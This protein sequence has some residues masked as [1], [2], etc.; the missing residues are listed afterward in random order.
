MPSSLGV[1]ALLPVVLHLWL[2]LL[3]G[4]IDLEL[5]LYRYWTL[6][7]MHDPFAD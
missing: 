4:F 2:M 5:D 6:F 7:Q 3:G 1:L